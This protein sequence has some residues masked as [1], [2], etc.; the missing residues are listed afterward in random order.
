MEPAVS[1][2]CRCTPYDAVMS[3]HDV[4][5]ACM[6]AAPQQ[7]S[8]ASVM[9]PRR[10]VLF[11][12]CASVLLGLGAAPVAARGIARSPLTPSVAPCVVRGVV[13]GPLGTPM[14]GARV[15]LRDATDAAVATVATD[16]HGSYVFATTVPSPLAG[17]ARVALFAEEWNGGVPGRF[18]VMYHDQIT[19]LQSAPFPMPGTA[20]CSSV[21]FRLGAVLPPTYHSIVP[22]D[23]TLW[24]S[25]AG[26]YNDAHRA[27]TYAT[28]QL[29]IHF[30]YGLPLPIR[31]WCDEA[32]GPCQSSVDSFYAGATT[33][34]PP[35]AYP[36]IA[37]GSSRV[38]PPVLGN[39][40][41]LFH[42]FGHVAMA[43][44]F[45][46]ALPGLAPRDSNHG[47]YYRNTGSAD[48]LSEGFATFFA[49]LV[50]GSDPNGPGAAMATWGDWA[51]PLEDDRSTRVW[52]AANLGEELAVAG[53]LHDV[54]DSSAD[55]AAGAVVTG[56][57]VASE[58][59]RT[60]SSTLVYGRVTGAPM[61]RTLSVSISLLQH[62]SIVRTQTVSAGP[63]GSATRTFV[64]PVPTGVQFTSVRVVPHYGRSVSRVDDDPVHI[65]PRRLWNVINQYRRTVAH[66]GTPSI[67]RY[68]YMVDVADLYQ[69]LHN[70]FPGDRD[71]NGI[72]DIAQIFIQH[73][74]FADVN[75]N[76]LHDPGELV[77]VTSHPA[78][79][80]AQQQVK[81]PAESPR[82]SVSP[83]AVWT[84]SMTGDP[85]ALGLHVYVH[86]PRDARNRDYD[87]QPLVDSDQQ[88]VVTVPPADS[89]AT[90]I[91]SALSPDKPPVVI[92]T[93][94]A[95]AFWQEA[96]VHHNHSFLK[97]DAA[98][99]APPSA[100]HDKREDV[101]VRRVA[102]P[103]G[104]SKFKPGKGIMI[105]LLVLIVVVAAVIRKLGPR[106]HLHDDTPHDQK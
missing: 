90:V 6:F 18:K 38:A 8:F 54:V 50:A 42:E 48:A 33:S 14:I 100:V 68:P 95:A 3:Q 60:P 85:A 56:V 35:A 2:S 45:G 49:S 28:Q 59:A 13:T 96:D 15:E 104:G 21:N 46:N 25:I 79:L 26:V 12:L 44:S 101:V 88:F 70:A 5:L 9:T 61:G 106:R 74:L 55:Y 29:G 30:D 94:S 4:W 11:A 77:G 27:S 24:S 39:D 10:I 86:F 62:G 91:L 37:V 51:V 69:A 102:T 99:S 57:R 81:S 65:A 7:I 103:A 98:A 32:G 20:A 34:S 92:D 72:D 105:T 43:N 64:F 87:Y 36:Y 1:G 58:I 80:D 83:P 71:H 78:L 47:G 19:Q 73:G 75:G 16:A 89:G 40:E 76:R 41:S 67:T 97:Y 23:P 52:D 22:T 17:S 82:F 84:A 31:A 63:Y 93:I 66:P 53:A